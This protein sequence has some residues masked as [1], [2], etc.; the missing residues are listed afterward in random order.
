MLRQHCQW[1]CRRHS[2]PEAERRD[3]ALLKYLPRLHQGVRL[4]KW[5]DT[6]CPY[7]D[8]CNKWADAAHMRAKDHLRRATSIASVVP[9]GTAEGMGALRGGAGGDDLVSW[10]CGDCQGG[11]IDRKGFPSAVSQGTVCAL[12]SDLSSDEVRPVGDTAD[13]GEVSL[14]E[15]R[16]ASG[17]SGHKQERN[18]G[19]L[20]SNH[21]RVGSFAESLSPTLPFGVSPAVCLG[22][23]ASVH[24]PGRSP[25]LALAMRRPGRA[26]LARQKPCLRFC[27]ASLSALPL[28]F[29]L[30]CCLCLA[31]QVQTLLLPV[32][33]GGIPLPSIEV[34]ELAS[35]VSVAQCYMCIS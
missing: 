29:R 26:R 18:V 1:E 30:C 14:Q 33:L 25:C 4:K 31:T 17:S 2:R 7:C 20:P 19:A 9:S 32:Y 5:W 15:V 16:E 10:P 13:D 23:R 11:Y 35:V 6:W 28:R 21:R 27:H 24:L 22:G 34:P 12:P 3:E 8:L